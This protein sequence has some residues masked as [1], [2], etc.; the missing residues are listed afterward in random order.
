MAI[1]SCPECGRSISDKAQACP[2]CGYPMQ[3]LPQNP[4]GRPFF[5]SYGYEYKSQR[6]IFGM[7]LIHIV[8]GLPDGRMKVARGFFAIGNVAVGVFALGGVAVGIISLGGV[9]LGLAVCG[10]AALGLGV[11]V[12][13]LATGYLAIGGAAIG[14]YAVGGLAIGVHTIFNDPHLRQVIES[15][16]RRFS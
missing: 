15:L 14:I 12:G 2:N 5:R 6:T 7:P 16:F 3:P 10:G 1:T 13:G 11:G 4:I 9:G 8:S